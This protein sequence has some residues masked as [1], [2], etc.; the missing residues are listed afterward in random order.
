MAK[1]C[2]FIDR[3][4]ELG[5]LKKAFEKRPLLTI[6]YGRRRLGKT[7]LVKEF[8]K[9]VKE[10]KVLYYT[11]SLSS[12]QYN[13]RMLLQAAESVANIDLGSVMVEDLN[14]ALSLLYR[15]GFRIVVIDEITYWVRVAPRVVS[16][17]QVFVDNTLPDTDM[18]LIL[19]GSHVGVMQN[20]VLGGGAP[21][22]GRAEVRLKLEMIPFNHTKNFYPMLT[23][24]D[25][26]RLY[27]LVGGVPFYNCLLRGVDNLRE[28][29]NTLLGGPGAPLIEEPLFMLRDELREPAV[30]N[31]ILSAIARGYDTPSRISQYTGIPLPHTSKYLSVLEV[32]GIVGRDVPLFR[33]KG[34]YRIL[35][36]PMRT[37]YTLVEPVRS[38][39]ELGEYDKVADYVLG[40][41]DEYTSRTWEG[42]ARDYLY[43]SYA[44]EGYD[45]A[46]RIVHK[47]MELDI[48]VVNPREKRA[49]VGEVK[50]SELDTSEAKRIRRKAMIKAQR[51]LPGYKIVNV[52]VFARSVAGGRFDWIV[53]P[54]DLLEPH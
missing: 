11:A 6:I 24:S 48:G 8:I 21:L 19:L 43:S 33:K 29:I 20:H 27:A 35:D 38:L 49:I 18:L 30:Y 36:P 52:Y 13:L 47:G 9:L 53:T 32:L 12:H 41:I 2:P 31:T 44:G 14:S 23:A 39:Y 51:L 42:L 15:L 17:L 1:E 25:L 7:R 3:A 45:M 22:Y 10:E 26:V 4:Y 46:G 5:I 50:W 34:V 37:Y 54:E 40:R 28:A 16:E